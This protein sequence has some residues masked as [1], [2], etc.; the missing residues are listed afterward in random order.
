MYNINTDYNRHQAGISTDTDTDLYL[1][2]LGQEVNG[3]GGS[4][5]ERRKSSPDSSPPNSSQKCGPSSR[6]SQE[7]ARRND[8]RQSVTRMDP[9][10]SQPEK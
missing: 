5:A 3:G 7:M 8:L 9:H 6:R 10:K 2:S 1:I 4:G